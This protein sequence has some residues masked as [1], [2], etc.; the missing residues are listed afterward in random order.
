MPQCWHPCVMCYNTDGRV[1]KPDPVR[2]SGFL[3]LDGTFSSFLSR[4]SFLNCDFNVLLVQCGCS[5]SVYH[6]EL[7]LKQTNTWVVRKKCRDLM[8]AI[9]SCR[10]GIFTFINVVPSC[11]AASLRYGTTRSLCIRIPW[12]QVVPYS[13]GSFVHFIELGVRASKVSSNDC[14]ILMVSL[15]CYDRRDSVLS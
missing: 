15:I 2:T 12:H 6:P 11:T 7:R 9:C 5:Q 4:L 8:N 14:S 3:T 10:M 13:P 1:K